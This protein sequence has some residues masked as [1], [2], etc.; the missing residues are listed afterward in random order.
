MQTIELKIYICCL[1]IFLR[2]NAVTSCLTCN[3]RKGNMLVR[4]L[5]SIGM[6]LR[7]EPRAPSRREL[8]GKAGKMLPRKVHPTWQP[9]LGGLAAP[10]D[11]NTPT[12]D[13]GTLGVYDD[14]NSPRSSSNTG[15]KKKKKKSSTK[16]KKNIASKAQQEVFLRRWFTELQETQGRRVI[17]FYEYESIVFSLNKM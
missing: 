4:D 8:A 16:K 13:L 11:T 14:N 3:G 6:K 5:K 9:Y 7:T 12:P 15:T 10:D 1:E 2:E 17:S